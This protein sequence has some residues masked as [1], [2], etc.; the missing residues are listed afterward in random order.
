MLLATHRAILA[1]AVCRLGS[2]PTT[3]ERI[4]VQKQ[5]LKLLERINKYHDRVGYLW[6][7]DV[8][9]VSAPS[10]PDEDYGKSDDE[11]GANPFSPSPIL[12]TD[13]SA[14]RIPLAMPSSIG[15]QQCAALGYMRHVKT[16][17]SLRIGQLNNTLQSIRI[18]LSCKAII[19]REKQ[20]Q[21]N[22]ILGSNH[23]S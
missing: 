11:D 18:G 1:T 19:F 17:K 2:R 12:Q 15:L 10:A 4:Q 13:H 8:G 14:E 21:K 9:D 3:R 5:R 22:Q 23:S 20:G 7:D 16:E 6:S